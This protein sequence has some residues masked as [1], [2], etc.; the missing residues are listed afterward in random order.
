LRRAGRPEEAAAA[1]RRAVELS[2]NPAERA[3][4]AGRLAELTAAQG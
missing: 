1:Y 3:Y 4:L 2:A